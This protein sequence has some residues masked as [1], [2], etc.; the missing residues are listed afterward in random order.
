VTSVAGAGRASPTAT[1]GQ[2]GATAART[3]RVGQSW[4]VDAYEAGR[5]AAAQALDLAEPKLALVFA[6]FAYDLPR[7]LAGVA[8]AAGPVPVTGC[9]TSGEIGPDSEAGDGVVVVGFGGAFDVRTGY[10]TGVREAPRA[11]GETAA[12]SLLPLPDADHCVTVLLTDSLG[13]DQ[14]EMIRGAYGVLG[15][16]VPLVGGGAGDNLKFETSRQ[17]IGEQVLSESVV[18]AWIGSDAPIG[19]S[20]Q[21]GWHRIGGAMMVTGS[22]GNT[23]LTFDD[24]PALDVY[25][26]RH[27]APPGIEHDPVAFGEF[28]LTRPLAIGRRRTVAIRHVLA[29]DPQQRSLVCV[30]SLPRGAAAWL[31]TGDADSLMAAAET[32]CV[33]AIDQLGEAP[34]L[35][36]LVFDCVAR[37]GVLGA[38]RCVEER[39]MMAARAGD[40]ALAGF[41]TYGE[42]AR[43]R[44][45]HGYHNQTIV[46]VALS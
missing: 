31:A 33:D 17:F 3:V 24:R 14:Q 40:A 37:Q 43:T 28:A 25:L 46:A 5:A 42:I 20:V 16:T 4:N 9:T 29:A 21:H 6:A 44:G 34:P 7:L 10:A 35:A 8:A 41:Y 38:A 18:A 23:V 26:E 15:A 30:A 2:S 11:V 45:V 22:S 27:E 1:E 12:R 19:L 32:A 13:S 36:L 39:Q